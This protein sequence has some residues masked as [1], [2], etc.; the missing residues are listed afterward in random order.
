[1]FGFAFQFFYFHVIT[2]N[3]NFIIMYIAITEYN[4][5][6]APSSNTEKLQNLI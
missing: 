2:D 4:L 6:N 5:W 1:M 3:S